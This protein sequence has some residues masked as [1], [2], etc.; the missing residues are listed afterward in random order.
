MS[1]TTNRL[2]ELKIGES[3]T[4][5]DICADDKF[6][7]RLADL[8]IVNGTRVA[9]LHKSPSGD[10]TAYFIKGTVIAL[11]SIDAEKIVISDFT[12][13]SGDKNEKD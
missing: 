11:R 5:T 9:A 8:G 12:L 6:K 7:S 13:Q 1:K 3:A 4:I 2:S 10:P